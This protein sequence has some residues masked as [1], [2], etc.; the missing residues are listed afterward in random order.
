MAAPAASGDSGAGSSSAAAAIPIRKTLEDGS[1]LLAESE[2]YLV[3]ERGHGTSL[4]CGSLV[5]QHKLQLLRLPHSTQFKL[6]V[7][8]REEDGQAS[9]KSIEV[10]L[11]GRVRMTP[12]L[13]KLRRGTHFVKP[14][15][16]SLLKAVACSTGTT[17]NLFTFEVSRPGASPILSLLGIGKRAVGLGFETLEEAM[18]WYLYIAA[19]ATLLDEKDPDFTK[20]L[21]HGVGLAE[22]AANAHVPILELS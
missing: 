13:R 22:H 17:V 10:P 7:H 5:N 11:D 4:S 3:L 6:V 15:G 12:A 18:G 2:A 9:G 1:R 20:A 19:C 16:Q 21:T 8:A 14:D